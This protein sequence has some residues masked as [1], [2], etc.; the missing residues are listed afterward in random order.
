MTSYPISDILV[1]VVFT[2]YYIYAY[3]KAFA[4]RLKV[5]GEIAKEESIVSS[6]QIADNVIVENNSAE[7]C[8]SISENNLESAVVASTMDSGIEENKG[9][10][11]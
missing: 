11:E 5:A 2:P 3:K 9:C 4:K 1:M 10:K 7:D 6:S 8:I